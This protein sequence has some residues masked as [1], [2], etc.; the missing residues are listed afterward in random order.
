MQ[1][2]GNPTTL[3]MLLLLL[4]FESAVVTGIYCRSFVRAAMSLER[5]FLS[6]KGG[7]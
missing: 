5:A 2:A 1:A 6:R 3:P 7:G 4:L